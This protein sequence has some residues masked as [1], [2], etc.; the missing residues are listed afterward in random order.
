MYICPECNKISST[1]EWDNKSLD[2]FEE[3]NYGYIE[4]EK[5]Q[6]VYICPKCGEQI[7]GINIRKT[8]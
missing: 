6:C 4:K 8:L 7:D 1:K 5:D 2:I 3:S